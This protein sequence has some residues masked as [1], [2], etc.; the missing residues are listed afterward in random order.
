MQETVV[1]APLLTADPQQTASS[2]AYAQPTANAQAAITS[3]ADV[4]PPTS[5]SGATV[6]D[7]VPVADAAGQLGVLELSGGEPTQQ[8]QASQEMGMLAGNIT[9]ADAQWLRD[10][11]SLS[12]DEM[13]ERL[14]RLDELEQQTTAYAQKISDTQAENSALQKTAEQSLQL[15]YLGFGLAA[16]FAL[17]YVYARLRRNKPQADALASSILFGDDQSA[18]QELE[19]AMAAKSSAANVAQPAVQ[20]VETAASKKRDAPAPALVSALAA[21]TIPELTPIAQVQEAPVLPLAKPPAPV[22]PLQMR[23]TLQKRPFVKKKSWFRRLFGRVLPADTT[24]PDS[25]VENEM[26]GLSDDERDERIDSVW[27]DSKDWLREERIVAERESQLSEPAAIDMLHTAPVKILPSST[28][29]AAAHLADDLA[30]QPGQAL[31]DYIRSLHRIVQRLL[32]QGQFGQAGIMLY[33]HV[34][35]VPQTSPWAYLAFLSLYHEP[36][37]KYLEMRQ[38]FLER[39][40]REA[41]QLGEE[42]INLAL[43]RGIADY[44]YSMAQ[45]SQ[46]WPSERAVLLLEEWLAVSNKRI[47]TLHAYNELFML[48]DV[49]EDLH[50]VSLGTNFSALTA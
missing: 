7:Q 20:K 45:L 16:L 46:S 29:S 49:L 2:L 34:R 22:A 11:S 30:P 21:K 28:S 44:Q 48:Y 17:A 33:E 1:P 41:P 50:G 36:T 47:F 9:K 8:L 27:E 32:D 13:A 23:E 6:Q 43:S 39:F 31:I 37:A 15:Q 10:A 18:Q 14:R 40:G 35:L 5:D 42:R 4:T 12:L 19:R 25:S 26:L 38:W 3:R 24:F